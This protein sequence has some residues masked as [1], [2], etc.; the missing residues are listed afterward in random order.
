MGNAAARPKSGAGAGTPE[1]VSYCWASSQEAGILASIPNMQSGSRRHAKW[2]GVHRGGGGFSPGRIREIG[3]PLGLD[4]LTGGD[5]AL[6][7][8][9]SGDHL[10]AGVHGNG[11]DPGRTRPGLRICRGAGWELPVNLSVSSPI[12]TKNPIT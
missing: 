4:G 12:R 2:R 5:N 8:G 9:G 6:G 7:A 1:I 10:E 3:L 11:I